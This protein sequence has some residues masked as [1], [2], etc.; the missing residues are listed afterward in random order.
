MPIWLSRPARSTAIA[1]LVADDFADDS[2][3]LLEDE[4]ATIMIIWPSRH[5]ALERFQVHRHLRFAVTF[6]VGALVDLEAAA[7]FRAVVALAAPDTVVVAAAGLAARAVLL[8]R[9]DESGSCP[10]AVT[11]VVAFAGGIVRVK[12][13]LVG[14]NVV[15]AVA[16]D[17]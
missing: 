14:S 8:A 15:A 7:T 17:H 16:G 4:H 11:F 6:G 13:P 3:E 5:H 9:E 10:V 2:M 12:T 1:R